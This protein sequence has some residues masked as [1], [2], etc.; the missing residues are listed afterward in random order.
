MEVDGDQVVLVADSDED[1][2]RQELPAGVDLDQY[3]REKQRD[4]AAARAQ[5][6]DEI[7]EIQRL[8][9]EKTRARLEEFSRRDQQLK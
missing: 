3:R 6:A 9:A 8:L 4:L 1:S 5:H 7:Q 2:G